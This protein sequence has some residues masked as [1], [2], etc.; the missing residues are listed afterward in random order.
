MAGD[1]V[2]PR[3]RSREGAPTDAVE[4]SALHAT[5]RETTSRC[6]RGIELGPPLP[7]YAKDALPPN[8][9]AIVAGI[10][11][12]GL[13]PWAKLFVNLRSTRET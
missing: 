4:P 12:V 11:R 7:R 5:L 13:T 6:R 1:Q 8:G 2:Q 9:R 3:M 10:V